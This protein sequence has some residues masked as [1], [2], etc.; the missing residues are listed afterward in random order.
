VS[1]PGQAKDPTQLDSSLYSERHS[2]DKNPTG[3]DAV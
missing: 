1:M 2:S 3:Y